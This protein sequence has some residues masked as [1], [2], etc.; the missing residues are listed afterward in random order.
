MGLSWFQPTY[1]FPV[2]GDAQHHHSEHIM[3]T[4]NRNPIG[5]VNELSVAIAVFC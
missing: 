1:S 5:T 2:P 3:E 4:S